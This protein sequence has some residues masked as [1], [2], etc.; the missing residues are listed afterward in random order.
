MSLKARRI[1]AAGLLLGRPDR[2]S[3]VDGNVYLDPPVSQFVEM[4]ARG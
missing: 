2:A 1:R 4:T 3:C